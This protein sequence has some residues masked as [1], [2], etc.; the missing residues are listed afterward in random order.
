MN[1]GI[2]IHE[3][4]SLHLLCAHYCAAVRLEKTV[5]TYS[6]YVVLYNPEVLGFL[7]KLADCLNGRPNL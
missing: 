3:S 2:L 6:S 5:I 4:Y 1:L 7:L